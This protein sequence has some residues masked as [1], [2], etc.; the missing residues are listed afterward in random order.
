MF[1]FLKLAWRN[2]FRNKRRTLI[3]GTAIGIGLA[4]LIFTDALWI[5]MEKNMIHS[6]TSSFLGEGQIHLKGFR[7]TQEVDLTINQPDKILKSLEQEEIIEHFAPRVIS[8]GMI[9]SPANVQAI[10]LVG[11][12]PPR[13][14]YLSQIDETLQQGNYFAS[15][16][17]RDIIIGQKLAELLEVEL[18]D[19]LVVTVSQAK[20]ADLSQDMFRVSGIYFF[21]IQEMDQSMAFILLPK[22]QEMLGIGN[23][24]HE[25]ALK[26]TS[27]EYGRNKNLPFWEKYSK[28]GNEA[29]GW[30]VL[31]PQLQAAFEMSRFSTW[32]TGLIL[33]GVVALGIINTMFMSIHERMFEFG[34]LRAVGTRPF[35]VARLII[36]EAGSLAIASI[37]LGNILG[38]IVTYIVSKTGIDYTGIE[39]VGVTFRELL[40]PEMKLSQFIIFPIWVFI[41]TLIAGI[42]PAVY[43]YKMTPAE[44]MRRSF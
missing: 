1:I 43:A 22:A 11:I 31:L 12:D 37:I 21:N 8:F 16:N 36:F 9:T 33:F 26:F 15:N 13:E 25:I 27:P 20:T 4:A 38:V 18:G 28:N 32:I 3:A 5:G 40:Y 42:Y 6:A 41:F 29:V 34:V 23:D 7:E 10:N 2:L 30:T 35:A 39:F 17:Q 44:S 19:R 24:I 14:K